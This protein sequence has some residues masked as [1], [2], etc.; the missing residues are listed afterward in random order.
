MTIQFICFHQQGANGET[1]VE[2]LPLNQIASCS[3]GE[4]HIDIV[5]KHLVRESPL[6][7]YK[8]Y[9]ITDSEDLKRIRKKLISLTLNSGIEPKLIG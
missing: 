4:H 6:C 5:T 2:F 3:A 9:R 1:Q 7:D 8:T